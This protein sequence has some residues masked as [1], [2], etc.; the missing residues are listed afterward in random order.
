MSHV[1]VLNTKGEYDFTE[2][3][4]KYVLNGE[5]YVLWE[6]DEEN[7]QALFFQKVNDNPNLFQ[8]KCDANNSLE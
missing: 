2:F 6:V 1:S 7:R 4:S 8:S 5:E 3:L